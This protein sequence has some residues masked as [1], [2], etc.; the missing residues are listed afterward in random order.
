[1]D[2]ARLWNACVATGVSEADYAAP[3]DTVSVCFSKG[4]GAPVGSALVGSTALIQ[5]ARRFR[6][7]FG[8][9]MRQAG[10]I[11]AGALYA[12]NHHRERLALD[13][14]HARQLALG[15]AELEEIVLEPDAVQTNIVTFETPSLSA[16][17]LVQTLAEQGVA[18]LATG[19][20]TIRAVTHLMV[21]EQQ[22]DS[23]VE[24]VKDAIASVKA[25]V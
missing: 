8:G 12:L 14:E 22:I 2:G 16:S 3:C 11:A 4:L 19:P 18:V 25:M 15:L 17:R 21:E 1:M 23:A 5:R 9:G 13:H 24:T 20:H 6:K 7:L 10:I